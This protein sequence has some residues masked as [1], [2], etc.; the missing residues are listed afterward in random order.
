MAGLMGPRPSSGESK[1]G[2]SSGRFGGGLAGMAA[3]GILGRRKSKEKAEES[4]A[5]PAAPQDDSVMMEMQS[6]SSNFSSASIAAGK[7]DV[8]AGF[9]Q[10]EHPMKKAL[11]RK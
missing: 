3:G 11:N 5:A 10:V 1:E 9:Q 8:P 6:E 2:A 4:G 7:M